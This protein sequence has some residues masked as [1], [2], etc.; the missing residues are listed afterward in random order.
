MKIALATGDGINVNKH[1]GSAPYF[2][3]AEA[4]A[5]GYTILE[6]RENTGAREQTD[7]EHNQARFEATVA[8]VSDCKAVIAAKIGRSAVSELLRSDIQALEQAGAIETLLA[9]YVKYLARGGFRPAKQP[10]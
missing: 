9:G 10:E 2:V 3:I 1:F 4:D 8:L 7:K 6:S 5:S